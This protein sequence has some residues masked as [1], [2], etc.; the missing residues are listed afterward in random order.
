MLSSE[1]AVTDSPLLPSL[2]TWTLEQK[3]RICTIAL[4]S[5]DAGPLSMPAFLEP[6]LPQALPWSQSESPRLPL[7]STVP[8]RQ[9]PA[10]SP[11]ML[12]L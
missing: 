3:A 4:P 6:S 12:C 11:S 2:Y 7:T 9:V 8:L 5:S 1:H 10:Y